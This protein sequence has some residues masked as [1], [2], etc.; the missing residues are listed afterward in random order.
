M[1]R[2]IMTKRLLRQYDRLRAAH[3]LRAAV[4]CVLLIIG[5]SG[6]AQDALQALLELDAERQALE[7]EIADLESANGPYHETLLEPLQA[8]ANVLQTQ[9]NLDELKSVQN[10]RL[11]ITRTILGFESPAVVPLL[12][13]QLAQQ[14]QR[15]EWQAASETL[16]H[17]RHLQVS[18]FGKESEPVLEVMQRQADWYLARLLVDEDR[19][20]A[21]NFLDSRE[22]VDEMLDL[23]EDRFGEDS[24]QLIPWLYQRAYNLAQMVQILNAE[25]RLASETLSELVRREGAARVSTAS[26]RFGYSPP[27]P[28][29]GPT[30]VTPV[31]DRSR[32]EMAIGSGYIREAISFIDDI[33]DIAEASDNLE[34]QGIAAIYHG[35]FQLLMDRGTARGKYQDARELLLAA[36]IS[37]ARIDAFFARPVPLPYHSFAQSFAALEDLQSLNRPEPADLPAEAVFVGEFTGWSEDLPGLSR[38]QSISEFVA[39][40]AAYNEVLLQFYI[41]PK[42]SVSSIDTLSA[43]PDERGV[44]REARRAL[45][46]IRFRPAFVDGKLQ[47][48]RDAVLVYRFDWDD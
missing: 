17:L 1:G 33:K 19:D 47:R 37:A 38:P 8:L 30:R 12:D 15:G 2:K 16:E 22:V 10:R 31:I 44:R 21:D 46:G 13:E 4:A 7:A 14:I 26:S 36:G 43:S 25:N 20:A 32:G 40:P 27:I 48:S 42:G 9:R 28:L 23:A 29:F 3:W 34:L 18:N 41:S 35:D 5:G 11:Q 39:E 24:E 45:D 6:H